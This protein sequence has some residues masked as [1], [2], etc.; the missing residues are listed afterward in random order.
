MTP[1]TF[2]QNWIPIEWVTN[3]TC[4]CYWGYSN[5]VFSWFTASTKRNQLP[6][7]NPS[8]KEIDWFCNESHVTTNVWTNAKST[9]PIQMLGF[10]IRYISCCFFIS[11]VNYNIISFCFQIMGFPEVVKHKVCLQRWFTSV[12]D[13]A[14]QLFGM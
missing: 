7:Y 2:K 4:K 12:S 5:I 6:Y 10:I 1:L 3:E 9:V 14:R 13:H 11:R 8:L